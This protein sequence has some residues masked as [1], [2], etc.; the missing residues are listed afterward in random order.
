MPLYPASSRQGSEGSELS[1]VGCEET[2]ELQRHGSRRHE[3]QYAVR[4][5]YHIARAEVAEHA[6][7]REPPSGEAYE[8]DLSQH[9]GRSD[10]PQPPHHDVRETLSRPEMPQHY[11]AWIAGALFVVLAER[12]CGAEI[13]GHVGQLIFGVGYQRGPAGVLLPNGADHDMVTV[14]RQCEPGCGAAG[15][16][17]HDDSDV[18]PVR[19]LDRCQH[20]A[21][22]LRD[23]STTFGVLGQR[24]SFET[25]IIAA[26][27]RWISEVLGPFRILCEL[28]DQAHS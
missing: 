25:K 1:A 6:V 14:G 21:R 28:Y 5:L 8:R 18:R 16:I 19:D 15:E 22:R 24:T 23:T 27:T 2:L 7:C 17:V 26:F 3:A 11:D 13:D 10:A 20:E 9:H 12:F 4:L